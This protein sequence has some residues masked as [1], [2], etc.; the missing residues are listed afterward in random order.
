MGVVNP[1]SIAWEVIPFS[2]V[3]DWFIP[4][5][6]VLEACTA[7]MG[8]SFVDSW[9]S[10]HL[11]YTLQSKGNLGRLNAWDVCIDEGSYLEK[12][13]DFYRGARD[14]FPAPEFYA[15]ITPYSTPRALNAL[16]VVHQLT[17]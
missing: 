10:E 14:S 9:T 12:G 8:L 2:F 4:V 17:H 3:V 11:G 16:A 7:T 6:Q 1:L 5:G 13:Y 15:D